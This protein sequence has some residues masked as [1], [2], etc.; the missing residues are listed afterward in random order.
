MP[1][2]PNN[3]VAVTVADGA[4]PQ[5][6]VRVLFQAADGSVVTAMTDATG[7]AFTDMPAGGNVTVIRTYPVAV[8]PAANRRF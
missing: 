2:P 4:T 7:V 1:P 3:R 8:P 5:A 6:N